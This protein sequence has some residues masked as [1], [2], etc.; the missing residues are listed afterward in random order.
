MY[1]SSGAAGAAGAGAALA[2]TGAPIGLMVG[3]S[4]VLIF[5]GLVLVRASLLRRRSDAA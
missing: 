3:F 1:S 5:I 2:F 4:I